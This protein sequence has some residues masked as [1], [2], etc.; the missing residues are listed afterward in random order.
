MKIRMW[1]AAIVAGA[2]LPACSLSTYSPQATSPAIFGEPAVVSASPSVVDGELEQQDAVVSASNRD[3]V[4]DRRR[5]RDGARSGTSGVVGV[6]PSFE[7]SEIN[8]TFP[9]QPLPAFIDTALGEILATPYVLGPGV[10]EREDIIS[11]RSVQDLS[12]NT[13][14]A[15]FETA[16]AEYGLAVSFESDAAVVIQRD[17]L[18]SEIPQIILARARAGVAAP[19]RPVIQFVEFDFADSAQMEA[20]LRQAFPDNQEL[21]IQV[22][23]DINTMTLTGISDTVD[24][25]LQLIS[26][27]DRPQFSGG[28]AVTLSPQFWDADE[29]AQT[30]VDILTIEGYQIGIGTRQQRALSILALDQTNQI[31]VFARNEQSLT[32]LIETARRL[33]EAS[34][35]EDVSRSF[36]YQVRNTDAEELATVIRAVL[37]EGSSQVAGPQT[38]AGAG[39]GGANPVGS[40]L[41]VD[42]FGNRLIFT[43]TRDEYDDISQLFEG[44]DTPVAEVLVEVTIAEVVLSDS[45]RYG[46]EFFFDTFGGDLQ[47]GTRGSLGLASSG[48]STV[49]TIGQVDLQAAASATNSRINILSTPRVV[50]RSGEAAEVQVGTDVPIIT[51]QRAANTQD[52]GS[53]DILQ[54]IQYRSTGVLL[55]VEPRVFSNDRIDLSV[56]QEVSSADENPNQ[57]IGSPIISNRRLTSAITLQDG[58]TA[59]LGGLISETVN[60]GSTGV[61]LVQDIPLIGNAFKTETISNDQRVLLVLVTPY[62]LNDRL[63]R[64]R[65]VE[66]FTGEV[67]DAFVSRLG[68]GATFLRYEEP[69]QLKERQ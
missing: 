50:A 62:I 16:I 49:A 11:L 58:Q 15:L 60:R 43:G 42:P 4:S 52:A 69:F 55:T 19:L 31:L 1:S 21:S 66:A 8:A 28:I 65:I 9:P 45:T 46:V 35:R 22:R 64:Q 39:P 5:V 36:I 18:R 41:A 32:H 14:F 6:P 38:E 10:A 53:T 34:E 2:V 29:L 67:N 51:S 61:P 33:D 57:A 25:A 63:D 44:L 7:G 68:A 3:F 59:V 23:R 27:L 20:I 37:G 12:P 56:T 24:S 40:R 13:F 26:Q 48:L 47:V 54:S 17:E 30:L